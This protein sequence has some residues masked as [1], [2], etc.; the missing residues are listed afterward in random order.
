M[1]PRIPRV[2]VLFDRREAISLREAAKI[3]GCCEST[4]RDWCSEFDLGR[5][6]GRGRWRVSRVALAMFLES[7]EVALRAYLAGDRAS[8]GVLDY[9]NRQNIP[10]AK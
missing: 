9:F 10:V 2:L 6:I 7:D 4:L 8:A 3:A 5:R 1:N